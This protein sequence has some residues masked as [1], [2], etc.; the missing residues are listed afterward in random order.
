M[1]I[2]FNKPYT[3]DIIT[4]DG[5][6]IRLNPSE[7]YAIYSQYLSDSLSDEVDCEMENII[8]KYGEEMKEHTEE[9]KET[10]IRLVLDDDYSRTE[11]TLYT[12]VQ[13][14]YDDMM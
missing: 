4:H 9:I 7:M 13:T 12:A 10:Y 2:E 1:K 5:E 14:V 8:D 11:E 3:C 6:S